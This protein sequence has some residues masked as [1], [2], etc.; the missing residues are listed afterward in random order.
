MSDKQIYN[1][2]DKLNPSE[3]QR[4]ETWR[5]INARKPK[6]SV[7]KALLIAAVITAAIIASSFGINALSGGKFFEPLKTLFHGDE[8]LGQAANIADVD[9]IYAPD[10]NYID[11]ETIVFTT[12]RGVVFYD[13]KADKPYKTVDLQKIGCV[14]IE[15]GT[16]FEEPDFKTHVF[17]DG[18]NVVVFNTQK[19]V[20]GREPYGNAYRYNLGKGKLVAETIYDDNAI[21]GYYRKWQ[22]F[23]KNYVDT[24]DAFYDYLIEARYNDGDGMYSFESIRWTDSKRNEQTSFLTVDDTD[25]RLRSFARGAKKPESK[26][27]YIISDK[28]KKAYKKASRL[29]K[30]KYTGKDTALAAII[31]YEQ[32]TAL[33]E[34]TKKEV[35]IPAYNVCGRIEQNGELLV[36]GNFWEFTYVRNGNTLQGISGS[37]NSRCYHLKKSGSGYK[38]ASVDIPREGSLLYEDIIK[39][40]KK[41]PAVMNQ[42]LG[43][44]SPDMEFVEMYVKYYD[45]DIEY[46]YADGKQVRIENQES[47]RT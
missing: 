21:R 3:R 27:L 20:I 28:D 38:V 18:K 34:L 13:R 24:F 40:T 9:P 29:P 10:I 26:L 8:V 7:R 23:R 15:F 46:Y 33:E 44:I 42:M 47:V 30:F 1:I 41:Y 2:F 31:K 39:M 12:T 45:L 16:E 14:Y 32:K 35:W 25:Y 22:A 17:C 6:K 36:F 37:E 43:E 19:G 11:D 4:E 5:R